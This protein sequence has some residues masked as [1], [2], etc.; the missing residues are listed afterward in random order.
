MDCTLNNT[1]D[2]STSRFLCSI[3][4]YQGI[5]LQGLG[6]PLNKK[7]PIIQPVLSKLLHPP[8]SL[9]EEITS[10]IIIVFLTLK[11]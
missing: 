5:M 4:F 3:L 6:H 2:I 11:V 9:I 1:E 8:N 10:F 7:Q